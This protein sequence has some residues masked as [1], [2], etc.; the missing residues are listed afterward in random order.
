MMRNSFSSMMKELS[1][2]RGAILMIHKAGGRREGMGLSA[3]T[4]RVTKLGKLFQNF[5]LP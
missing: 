2:F 4:L 1:I 5:L 3:I